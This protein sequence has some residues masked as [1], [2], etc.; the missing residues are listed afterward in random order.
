MCVFCLHTLLG[1]PHIPVLRGAGGLLAK[2]GLQSN[3]F[4]LPRI[5]G[6]FETETQK[7]GCTT[8][9]MFLYDLCGKP[10]GWIMRLI[11]E[12]VNNYGVAILIFTII[13]KLILF[14][15]SYK[16]QANSA[17][18]QRLN[19]K[20]EKLRKKYKDNPQK[21]QEEQAK[22]YQE[23][24]I[25]PMASCLPM[26]LQFFLLFGIL[27]VVYKPMT[28]ILKLKNSGVVESGKQV[29][30]A[31]N[32]KTSGTD[33]RE[34][35]NI[36]NTFHQNPDAFQGKEGFTDQV[37]S[38]LNEFYNNFQIFGVNLGSVPQLHPDVWNASAVVLFLIPFLSG[39]LQLFMTIYTQW[40]NKKRNPSMAN[41]G[42]M[43]IMLYV[44]PIF[45][46]VFAFQVPAGVGFYWACSSFFSLIQTVGLN[47]YFTPE[48]IE[49]IMAKEEKKLAK[50][51]ASGKK[52]FMTRMMEAQSEAMKQREDY[53]EKS[54]DM[55]RSELSE[56]NRNTLREARKRM[57][58]KYGDDYEDKD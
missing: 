2:G 8:N 35:L 6:S 13:T 30:E 20:L 26:F 48:R 32:I 58:E 50:K 1:Y 42:C 29:M 43:N 41:M 4:Y 11:Y 22:L 34:E 55:S 12:V 49:K 45:S 54:K 10:F 27:D 21:L 15:I 28:Y 9:M 16:Q 37:V 36:L 40:I 17:K 33:L 14:P 39:V 23:E 52:N 31:L 53:A 56:H 3:A 44:M 38:Q 46:V 57:A 18:M 19:P 25:N 24:N 47:R 51:Y 5:A 7:K